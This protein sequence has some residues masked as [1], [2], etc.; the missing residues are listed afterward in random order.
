[1]PLTIFFSFLSNPK[2]NSKENIKPRELFK[3]TRKK[4]KKGE[5]ARRKERVGNI[6]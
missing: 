5:K 4:A 3:W 6:F 1:L 2:N